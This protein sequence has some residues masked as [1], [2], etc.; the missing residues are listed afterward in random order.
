L[1]KSDI[2]KS[3]KMLKIAL[4]K[5]AIEEIKKVIENENKNNSIKIG[6]LPVDNIYKFYDENIIIPEYL[7]ENFITKNFKLT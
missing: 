3:K 2:E 6:I 1:K 7:V 5:K 4:K